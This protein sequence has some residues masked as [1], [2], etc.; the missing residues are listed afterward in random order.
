MQVGLLFL[1]IFGMTTAVSAQDIELTNDST[2]TLVG[3]S[4]HS[5]ISGKA[6]NGNDETPG[7][8]YAGDEPEKPVSNAPILLF[9]PGLNNVAQIFWED[10]DMYQT[11]RDA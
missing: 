3:E 4:D 7:E 1:F 10:N 5:T 8:W 6:G 11:A 2:P 9:V